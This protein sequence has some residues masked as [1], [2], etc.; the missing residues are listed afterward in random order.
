MLKA[1]QAEGCR[2]GHALGHKDGP[3]ALMLEY[4]NLPRYFLGK[5]QDKNP[6]L[7]LP[8]DDI[9]ANYRFSRTFQ[10]SAEGKA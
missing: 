7:I 2:R 9:K 1:Q 10:Y 4:D 3:V 8:S 5:V 6:E